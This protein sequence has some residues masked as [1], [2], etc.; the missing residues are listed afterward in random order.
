MTGEHQCCGTAAEHQFCVTGTTITIERLWNTIISMQIDWGTLVL[1]NDCG[2]PIMVRLRTSIYCGT[3]ILR[4]NITAEPE[5]LLNDYGTGYRQ[6][7]SGTLILWNTNNGSAKTTK[8]CGT[9]ILYCGTTLL[10]NHELMLND[11]G[12]HYYSQNDCGTLVMWNTNK[13]SSKN[14]NTAE[15][16]T[17]TAEPQLLPN[18]TYAFIRVPYLFRTHSSYVLQVYVFRFKFVVLRLTKTIFITYL[19]KTV[20]FCGRKCSV[21]EF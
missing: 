3:L 19:T 18:D 2:T 5:I 12:T 7:G 21:A 16:N 13:G 17:N 15:R 10:R 8:Y 11:F 20:Y 9:P 6:N 1:R 14:A 4:K